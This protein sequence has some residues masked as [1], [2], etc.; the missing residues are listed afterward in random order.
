MVK[1]KVKYQGNKVSI[2][3]E[4]AMANANKANET[5]LGQGLPPEILK[6]LKKLVKE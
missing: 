6:S 5:K 4:K 1:K 3:W 2:W